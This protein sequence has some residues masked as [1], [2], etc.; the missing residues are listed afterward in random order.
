MR[1]SNS[2]RRA[3]ERHAGNVNVPR[4]TQAPQR[5]A[6]RGAL[7]GRRMAR[8]AGVEHAAADVRGAR[9]AVGL[10]PALVFAWGFEITPEGLKRESE[11]ERAESITPHTG[12]KLDRVIMVVLALAL[13]YFAFDK[14]ALAPQ[15]AAEQASVARQEGRSE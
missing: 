8:G 1:R 15:R 4:R 12:K 6:H 11:V 2:R 14:F 7:P 9:L 10:L 13:G 5:P 3:L